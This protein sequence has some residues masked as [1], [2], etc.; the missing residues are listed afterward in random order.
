MAT[1][2]RSTS[3]PI[4]ELKVT[5]AESDPP[6]WRRIQVP[7]D[8][9]LYKLHHIL[10]AAMG[11]TNSHLY[12][13]EDQDGFYGEPD[14]DWGMDI[15]SARRTKLSQIVKVENTRFSYVYDMGD[16]WDHEV[17]VEK[18]LPPEPDK[19]YP[20][21]LAGER[22]CPPEDCGGVWGYDELLETISDPNHEDYEEM[23]EWLGGKF[24]PEAFNM[25]QVNQ[26]LRRIR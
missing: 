8:T 19:P 10:Q 1:S 23:M 5:L 2:K 24:D 22:A 17:M 20:V 15:K 21:C 18:V 6:I 14:P 9:T 13:F 16:N 12:Q 3:E 25:E 26:S 11:W 4:F 7:S